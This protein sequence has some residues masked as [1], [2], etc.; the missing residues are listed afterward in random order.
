LG[1]P[2]PA[3]YGGQAVIEGVMMRG[4]RKTAVA[5]RKP[6]RSVLVEAEANTSV[7][8]RLPLLKLPLLRGVVALFESLILGIR[9]LTFSASQAME[10]EEEELTTRDL[11]L[12]VTIALVFAIG[13]FVLLP[14]GAGWLL[15]NKLSI[16]WQNV[17]EGL[18]RLFLLV[19]YIVLIGRLQDIQRVFQYHGAEHKVINALEAGDDLNVAKVKAYSTLHPRC[20]TSFL[21]I[22]VA[23]T[24]VFFTLVGHGSIIWRLASRLALLPLVAGLAY[25]LLKF[26]GRY[27]HVPIVRAIAA[28]GLWLQ[29][30][31]TREPDDDM[32][33]VALAALAAAR[34]EGGKK[35]VKQDVGEIRTVGS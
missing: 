23:L 11:V 17:I 19:A 28:P 18:L 15:H 30:L 7:T 32:L 27:L 2:P 12:T 25:E 5:I 31:T 13:I 1:A 9:Y 20:G 10:E 16:V 6:D 29:K 4:P 22:V 21:L 35:E 24:I 14:A 33:E 3:V 26:T 34:D 8:N